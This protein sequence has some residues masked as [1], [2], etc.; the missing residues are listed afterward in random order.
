VFAGSLGVAGLL[1]FVIALVLLGEERRRGDHYRG[2]LFTGAAV[3][4]AEAGLFL[5]ESGRL[6][7]IPP[8]FL[9][10]AVRPL[11]RLVTVVTGF[12]GSR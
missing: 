7:W 8:I 2:T 4:A 11:R 10:L 12:G 9:I 3:G 5:A 1:L 6:L